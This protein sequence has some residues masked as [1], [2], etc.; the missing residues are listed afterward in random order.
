MPL[1]L[2]VI[3]LLLGTAATIPAAEDAGSIARCP[4]TALPHAIDSPRDWIERCEGGSPSSCKITEFAADI[5]HD[6]VAELFFGC[7][8]TQ[9]NAG[10]PHYVFRRDGKQYR[11]LGSV[12]LHPKAFRVLPAEQD[13]LPKMILYRRLSAAEGQLCTVK[14]TGGTF[15]IVSQEK[16]EPTGR[17]QKRYEDLFNPGPSSGEPESVPAFRP[18]MTAS[19]ALELAERYIAEH[20]VDVSAQYVRS[21]TLVFDDKQ[22]P[23]MHYWHVQWAW[24]RP[25]LGGEYGLRVYMDG[26]VQ[27]TPLG[28]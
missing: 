11:Y 3:F 17:D 15:Q 19:T 1:P 7:R 21:V 16:I 24:A 12:F 26:T 13:G 27:P 2:I 10:G 4:D 25:R 5:D 6:G 23:A 28:P 9:G 8:E 18:E 22:T 20:R 14:Y